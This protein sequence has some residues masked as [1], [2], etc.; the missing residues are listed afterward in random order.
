MTMQAMV[1]DHFGGPEVLHMATLERPC[2]APRGVIV[3]VAYAGVNPADWKTREG[4]LA[5]FFE[6]Q[7]PFVLGFDAAGVVAEL[8]EGVTDLAIGDRVVTASNMGR[9]E[10]GTYAQYVASDRER[11]VKLPDW[12]TFA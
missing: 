10:R 1:L 7:F 3:Q 4:W 6:Y 8:G 5:Q 11:V 12:V 2:A 9:G